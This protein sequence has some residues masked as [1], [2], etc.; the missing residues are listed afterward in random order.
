MQRLEK[1]PDLLNGL[2]SQEVYSK[3]RLYSL[4]K[5]SFEIFKTLFG[6]VYKTVSILRIKINLFFF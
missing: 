6:T 4:D 1:V 5:S 2:M 3:A